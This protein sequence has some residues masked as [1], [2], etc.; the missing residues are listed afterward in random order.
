MA[1]ASPSS[2]APL[3]N[4]TQAVK[5]MQ[6]S[7]YDNVSSLLLAMIGFVGFFV[8]LMFLVWLTTV[9][10]FREATVPIMLIEEPAGRG[11]AAEGY[12]RDMAEPGLEELE[13]LEEPQLEATLEAVT[14]AVTSQMA[15]LDSISTDATMT[16]K[17]SGLGDSRSAGEGGEG[18]DIIPRWERWQI[19]YAA[20]NLAKYKSQLDYFKIELGAA[21]GGRP[22]IDYVANF[23]S[24]LKKRQGTSKEEKRLY[25]TWSR[26][27]LA[28]ADRQIIASSGIP[29]S[30][31]VVMQFYPEPTEN[32]L[33]TVELQF[34]QTKKITHVKF[35]RKTIF[36][37][38]Q[39][40][41]QYQYYVIDQLYRNL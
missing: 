8:L 30:N 28:K 16:G 11:E 31:R 2:S 41:S 3:K 24:G 23:T 19:Q 25:M 32:L 9:I 36:G 29:V 4:D 33:A 13:E 39:S 26:G 20:D 14:D 27:A 22:K 21:G 40:G 15:S 35:I 5:E 1:T 12:E 10:T 6:V 37:V 38:R 7:R 18:E 34:A 17:G